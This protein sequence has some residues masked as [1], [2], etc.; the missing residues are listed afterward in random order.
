MVT[1]IYTMPSQGSTPHSLR[2]G[3]MELPFGVAR[4]RPGVT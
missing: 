1:E 3:D 2:F 4:A